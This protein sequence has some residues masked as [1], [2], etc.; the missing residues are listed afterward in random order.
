MKKFVKYLKKTDLILDLGCGSGRDCIFLAKK[1]F[2]V[3]GID[4]SPLAVKKA[5]KSALK[6][7]L[8]I[9]FDVGL[10]E[11]LPYGNSFFDKIYSG[12]T[13]QHTNIMKTSKEMFRIL[14]KNGIIYSIIILETKFKKTGK[15]AKNYSS[16]EVLKVFEMNFKIIKKE[17]YEK[18][19]EES[20]ENEHFHKYLLLIMKKNTR[21]FNMKEEIEKRKVVSL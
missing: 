16:K 5:E 15:I 6:N 7:K 4:L 12:Y 17:E 10:A 20:K 18:I 3:I 8:K 1:G 14:K 13:L 9:H 21:L 19:D 11:N 2:S